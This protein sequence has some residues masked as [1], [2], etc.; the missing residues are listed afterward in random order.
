MF[1]WTF[2]ISTYPETKNSI[3]KACA[4]CK[5]SQPPKKK[6]TRCD[7]FWA[8]SRFQIWVSRIRCYSVKKSR[9]RAGQPKTRSFF[10]IKEV[11][12]GFS[13]LYT[14]NKHDKNV[15][16]P[17]SSANDRIIKKPGSYKT[18]CAGISHRIAKL[19]NFAKLVSKTSTVGAKKAA[20]LF[21]PSQTGLR[22]CKNRV[23]KAYGR[24]DD[25]KDDERHRRSKKKKARQQKYRSGLLFLPTSTKKEVFKRHI[26]LRRLRT[27]QIDAYITKGLGRRY[28]L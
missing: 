4:D 17:P 19:K 8:L 11:V 23:C 21:L 16:A 5:E 9:A 12:G 28:K 2:L 27:I 22:V 1:P 25:Y 26:F 18:K 24:R 14:G 13:W 7:V 20:R 6:E 3:S 10:L 15:S